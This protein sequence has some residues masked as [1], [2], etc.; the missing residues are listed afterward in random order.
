MTPETIIQRVHSRGVELKVTPDGRRL[1]YAPASKLDDQLRELLRTHK[2]QL[3]ESLLKGRY[4]LLFPN[5]TPGGAKNVAEIELQVASR[6]YALVWST[7]LGDLVAFYDDVAAKALIPP[8]FTAY[9]LDE[10]RLF[11]EGNGDWNPKTLRLIQQA[12]KAGAVVRGVDLD[13]RR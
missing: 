7:A 10:L 3:I 6:G 9:S 4:R 13:D 1:Q 5:A 2:V 12:K 8:A 11:E